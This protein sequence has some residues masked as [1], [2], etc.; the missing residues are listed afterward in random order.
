MSKPTNTPIAN[1]G[2]SQ[3]PQ[4][5]NTE[6]ALSKSEEEQADALV[7]VSNLRIIDEVGN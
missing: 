4:L 6:A 1:R 5:A 2:L 3:Q 7:A